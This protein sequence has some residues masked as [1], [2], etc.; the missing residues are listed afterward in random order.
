MC[1]RLCGGI[2]ARPMTKPILFWEFEIGKSMPNWIEALHS[3]SAICITDA[4]AMKAIYPEEYEI[5]KRL[6]VDSV[7]GVPFGPNPVGILAIRNPTR[8]VKY[9]SALSDII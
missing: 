1:G 3:G 4:K 8:Y 2:T 9:S 7:I 6:K 5:Y